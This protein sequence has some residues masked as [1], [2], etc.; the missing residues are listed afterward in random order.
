MKSANHKF[1]YVYKTIRL[2]TR[3][4]YY[5]VHS[6]N[7]LND[8]YQGSGNRIVNLLKNNEFLITGVIQ[9]FETRADALMFEKQLVTPIL[10]EDALCMNLVPGGAGTEIIY[11][12]KEET[13]KKLSDIK[14]GVPAS[15]SR[16]AKLRAF[17]ANMSPEEKRRRINSRS[18]H[19][20]WSKEGLEKI[21]ESNRNRIRSANSVTRCHT[22][23]T[24]QKI[25]NSASGRKHSEESKL[26]MSQIAKTRKQPTPEQRAH[27][28]YITPYGTFYSSNKAAEICGCAH[29][30]NII[31][32][33]KS[34]RPK[35]NGYYMVKL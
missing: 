29:G 11:H 3:E 10:L 26:K 32:R 30:N 13:R 1:H 9:F 27:F 21:R 5:G 25:A 2:S 14:K 18:K 24:K 4:Y 7:N 34:T 23:E 17:W 33:C 6:T 28:L 19:R 15:E 8:G 35:W 31:H 16:K 20:N 22:D 12:T